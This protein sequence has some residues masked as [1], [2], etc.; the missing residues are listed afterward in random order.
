MVPSLKI[1]QEIWSSRRAPS[2]GEIL[3]I[4]EFGRHG[5][6]AEDPGGVFGFIMRSPKILETFWA[7][8]CTRRGVCVSRCAP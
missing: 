6:L 4:L 5:A 2:R 7:S 1:L 3:G 8:R